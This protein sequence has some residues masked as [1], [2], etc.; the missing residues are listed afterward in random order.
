MKNKLRLI[1]VSMLSSYMGRAL[2]GIVT[3]F[4]IAVAISAYFNGGGRG[5]ERGV[6]A[7]CV[8][9]PAAVSD[10]E[11][12]FE[13]F[14]SLL[15]R[16]T[17]RPVVVTECREEWPV[18]FD[19]YVMP[20]HEYFKYERSLGIEALYEIQS[21]HR[22]TD[23]AVI[24]S[25]EPVNGELPSIPATEEIVFSHPMSVNGFWVQA[26]ALEKSGFEMPGDLRD[27]EFAGSVVGGDRVIFSVLCGAYRF[28]ACR[29][30]EVTARAQDGSVGAGEL[31]VAHAGNV[32]PEMM[33]AARG[34]DSSYYKRHLERI[35]RLLEEVTS[36]A[37]EDETVGLLKS[38]GVR[39]LLPLEPER[40]DEARR[41]FENYGSVFDSTQVVRP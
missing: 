30:S 6:I 2:T 35:A 16:A 40:I 21:S 13:P 18:G 23:K 36:P 14:R 17:L 15:G 20:V 10:S 39:R 4:V 26:A 1:D 19:L 12:I 27:L 34:D 41:L 5:F 29:L 22:Q 28:G 32:L 8:R 38:R 24:V 25:R 3:L 33:I 37:R 9:V 31:H 7:V 11:P